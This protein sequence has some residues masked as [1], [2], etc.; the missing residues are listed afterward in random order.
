MKIWIGLSLAAL[1]LATGCE[2]LD[3]EV[4]QLKKKEEETVIK[5]KSV[6]AFTVENQQD[7]LIQEISGVVAPRKE[8]SLSF[9]RSGKIDKIYVKKGSVV[10]AGT[11]LASLDTSVWQQEVTA[12]QGQ[13]ASANIRRA[14]ALQGADQHEVNTQKLQVEKARQTANKAA[15]EYAQGK[16]LYQNGAISKD[17][18]DQ[19]ALR[20][21]QTKLDL[22]EQELRYGKLLEGADRLDVEEANAEVKQATVQLLR[23]QQ[24]AKDARLTAPF[25]GVV[26]AV[27]QTES[28]QT[29]PGSEVIRLVDTTQWLVQ[30]QVESDQ[31]GNWQVGKPVTVRSS[32]GT[33]AE[34]TVHFVAPVMDQQTGTYPVEVAVQGDVATW[35]G[36]MTVI[37][38]YLVK[39]ANALLVPV[40]SVGISEESYYVMKIDNNTLKKEPVKVGALYGQYYEVVEGLEA[41]EQIVRTGLSYVIDGEAVKVADE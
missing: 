16:L 19:L 36:G 8:L 14:K 12:A 20:E 29:G 3:A 10:Q 34:G 27:T 33:Q 15:E 35:R 9:G 21:K 32:D 37:C 17:E 6:S 13:V 4:E 11:L 23:A 24:E 28:E 41:G 5:V 39:S 40:T 18:L 2:K 38:Q 1:L 22:Q 26:A 25:T 30:L 31:I 7:G